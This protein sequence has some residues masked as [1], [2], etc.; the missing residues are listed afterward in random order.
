MAHPPETTVDYSNRP[1]GMR[2]VPP[3]HRTLKLERYINVGALPPIPSVIDWTTK[4]PSWPMFLNDQL[5]CCVI[6]AMAHQEEADSAQNGKEVSI[7]DNDILTAYEA[8]GGYVPGNPA[9]DQGCDPTVA[10]NYWR[11][12]GIAGNKIGA[13]ASVD[14]TNAPMVAAAM[15]LFGGLFVGLALPISAQNQTLWDVVG[16]GKT[17]NSAPGSWGG[18]MVYLPARRVA[19]Q[20]AVVTWGEVLGMTEAFLAAYSFQQTYA[21]I[22]AAWLNGSQTAPSGVNLTQLQA[23]LAIVSGQTPPWTPNNYALEWTDWERDDSAYIASAYAAGDVAGAQQQ[24][25]LIQANAAYI[26]SLLAGTATVLMH[27]PAVPGKAS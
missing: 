20:Y 15:F 9:T 5:G 17:G 12:T 6:A 2:L 23:D 10:L 21:V 27:A 7:V 26:A 18:H 19:N 1:L 3:D 16:D 22:P 11:Q 4:V 13:F 25:A 24:Q 14:P 8:V